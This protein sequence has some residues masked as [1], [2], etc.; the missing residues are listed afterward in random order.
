MLKIYKTRA[1]RAKRRKAI[2][3]AVAVHRA[4]M[5]ERGLVR[6]ETFVD[7]AV[8]DGLRARAKAAGMTLREFLA[9]ILSAATRD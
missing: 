7:A 8:A 5:A 3:S 2:R 6:I 1:K 9:K 4:A